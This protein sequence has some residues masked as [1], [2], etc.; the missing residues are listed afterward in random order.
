[1]RPYTLHQ[2]LDPGSCLLFAEHLPLLARLLLID[3][4]SIEAPIS[5]KYSQLFDIGKVK[6]AGHWKEKMIDFL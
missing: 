4:F 3:K 6:V 5:G 1:M 2:G